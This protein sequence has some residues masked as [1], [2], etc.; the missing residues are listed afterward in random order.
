MTMTRSR[1]PAVRRGQRKLTS[2]SNFC[3]QS[4]L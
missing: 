1:S 2:G 3:M 4:R